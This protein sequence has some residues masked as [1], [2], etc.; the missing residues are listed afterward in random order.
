MTS[1]FYI[2]AISGAVLSFIVGC[3]WY[4]A[5]FGKVWQKEM[6]LS[7]EKIKVIFTPK[8]M[9]FAFIC[10]WI[11]SFCTIGLL[12]NLQVALVYKVLMIAAI[13]IFQGVKLSLF[14][15]KSIKT[16]FINEGYRGLSVIILAT[17]FSIFM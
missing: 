12:F 1:G 16:I 6:Q 2:A 14:D 13:I 11:A 4:T 15:G 9:A 5:L 10:E 3:L 17:T 8:R 7:D